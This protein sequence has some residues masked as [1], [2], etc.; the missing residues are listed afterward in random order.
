[1]LRHISHKHNMVKIIKGQSPKD[2]P[3]LEIISPS[4]DYDENDLVMCALIGQ[5]EPFCS[6]EAQYVANGHTV[7][8]ETTIPT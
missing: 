8:D 7:Y 5:T 2:N 3:E 1:M 6:F 4:G